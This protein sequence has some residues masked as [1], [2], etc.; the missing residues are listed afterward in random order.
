M[1]NSLNKEYQ[2][3]FKLNKITYLL[4]YVDV[5]YQKEIL[6]DINRYTN[7]INQQFENTYLNDPLQKKNKTF[8]ILNKY[9]DTIIDEQIV[10]LIDAYHK[11]NKNQIIMNSEKEALKITNQRVNQDKYVKTVDTKVDSMK[12]NF[13]KNIHLSDSQLDKIIN[14]KINGFFHQIK[15]DLLNNV[16]EVIIK[17]NQ[18]NNN[19]ENIKTT[20]FIQEKI[21]SFLKIFLK[22]DS[23]Y[24]N[25]F[26]HMNNELSTIYNKLNNIKETQQNILLLIEKYN[27]ENEQKINEVE[28][29]I[30]KKINI[31]LS[32]KIKLLVNI[33]NTSI[34]DQLKNVNVNELKENEILE[35]LEQKL[36]KNNHSSFSKNNFDLNF[37]KENNEIQLLYF[38]EIISSIQ[39]N[40]KGLIGPKGPPG[41]KGDKGDIT[42][43][44]NIEINKD[45]TV[46]FVLQN[47]TDI[48]EVN[49]DNKLPQGPRGE[50]GSKGEKGDTGNIEMNIKWEQ[51]NVMKI[52]KEN[53]NNVQFL[54]SLSIGENGHCLK[55]NS[56]SIG[57]SICYKENS[58]TLGNNAKTFNTNSIAFFGNTLGKNAFSYFAEDVDENCVQFGSKEGHHYNIEHI[59]FKA[60]TIE[61]DTEDFILNNSTF[62]DKEINALEEKINA[63]YEEI[64]LI[65][66][67]L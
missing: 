56:I 45:D 8:E 16:Q 67:Q 31:S 24:K 4:N 51:E 47:G 65:K 21:Q 50:K 38:G 1:N 12:N 43:I 23:L 44:R 54:K 35:K 59:T 61:F 40:L 11:E 39:L 42:H 6:K 22:D 53:T 46:K 10:Y 52:N 15:Q 30:F 66:K 17:T 14:D 2:S 5:Y 62:K 63:L 9:L 36:F 37:S 33:F 19:N 18:E 29:N 27:S 55:N 28:T 20:D 49:T 34:A 41:S 64:N 13:C 26:N 58:L 3:L 25:V 48:Y 60:K 7:H 32:E 57:N